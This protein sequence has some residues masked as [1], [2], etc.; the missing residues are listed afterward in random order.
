MLTVYEFPGAWGVPTVSPFCLKLTT[1]LR[2][3]GV[4]HR[5]EK[6]S[7]PRKGPKGKLPFIEEEGEILA[8]SGRIIEHLTRKHGVELDAHLDAE[9]RAQAHALRR[10]VEESLYFV[11]VYLRWGTDA[12]WQAIQGPYFGTLPSVAR[13]FVPAL[14]RRQVLRTLHGQGIGRGTEAEANAHGVA[15]VDALAG[16]LGDR[17]HFFGA[18]SSLDAIVYAFI[19]SFRSFPVSSAV[20]ERIA[21]HAALV[22]HA[23]RVRARYWDR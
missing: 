22:D 8:D 11:L 23:D 3:A 6:L 14:A 4:E 13:L 17:E 15:D 1:W 12:G 19:E 9:Q 10:M 7:D 20:K 5:T 21:H 16:A 18:P 2:M